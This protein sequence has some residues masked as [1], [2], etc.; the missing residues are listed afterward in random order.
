MS[1]RFSIDF[2]PFKVIFSYP[3]DQSNEITMNNYH[4]KLCAATSNAYGWR[5]AA[6]NPVVR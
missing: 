1:S 3:L 6:K 4:R 5:E 2:Y